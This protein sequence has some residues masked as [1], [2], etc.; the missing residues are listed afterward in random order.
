MY[1]YWISYQV[2]GETPSG[3]V[4]SGRAT[5]ELEFDEV[6]SSFGQIR[7]AEG[8]LFSRSRSVME[9]YKNASCT[10]REWK[11]LSTDK[12]EPIVEGTYYYWCLYE[13]SGVGRSSNFSKIDSCELI[14]AEP[15]DNLDQLQGEEDKILDRWKAKLSQYPEARCVILTWQL[16]RLEQ[17]VYSRR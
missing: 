10:I 15:I 4:Y 1:L 6:I 17:H 3:E 9:R 14:M 8:L 13:L 16:L 7:M 12:P 5:S 11:L 2:T